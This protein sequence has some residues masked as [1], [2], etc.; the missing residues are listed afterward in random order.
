MGEKQGREEE[1]KPIYEPKGAAKEY[2]DYALNIYTGCPH[3]CYYCFAPQVLHKDRERFHSIVEPRENIVE[4]TRKQLEREK[5]TG[6]LIHLCFTC[7]PYPTGCDTTTTREIIKLLKEHGN[8][9]QILTKGDGSKDFDILDENDWYGVTLDGLGQYPPNGVAELY[10][11]KSLGIKTWIS[12]EP[13]CDAKNVLRLLRMA[14][15]SRCADRVKIGKLN[16]HPSSI[17]WKAFGEEA[18]RICKY[19]GLDY[20]IKDSLREEMNK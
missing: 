8:H 5:I 11:A 7:D 19:F 14:G 2:G 10:Q 4:E 20:Y 18:E 15:E 1:M 6:K 16:Y 12:F 3:R 13:V 17:N 9:V